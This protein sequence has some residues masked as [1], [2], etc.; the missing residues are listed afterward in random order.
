M[1]NDTIIDMLPAEI[2]ACAGGVTVQDLIDAAEAAA[3]ALL[4][5]IGRPI[6]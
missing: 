1:N 2:D 5:M 6:A 4:R 3:N